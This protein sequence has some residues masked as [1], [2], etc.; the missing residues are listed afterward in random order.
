MFSFY[1]SFVVSSF[2]VIIFSDT[3]VD[4]CDEF[5]VR[6]VLFEPSFDNE[7]QSRRYDKIA[8]TAT[9]ISEQPRLLHHWNLQGGGEY[10][11]ATLFHCGICL[12]PDK[13]PMTLRPEH[14]ARQ[15]AATRR[16]NTS[17]QQISSCEQKNFIENFVAATEFCRCN[18][19]HKIKLV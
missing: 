2:V 15:I 18:M 14:T 19:S 5:L 6:C 7:I 8:I 17:Q 1:S 13:C 10:S 12:L 11:P 16:S 3:A 4:A 9:A